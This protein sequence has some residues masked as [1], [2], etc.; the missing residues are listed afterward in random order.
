MTPKEEYMELLPK[1]LLDFQWLEEG[2]RYYLFRTEL[3][4][5][6]HVEKVFRYTP[7]PL[8]KMERMALGQL[9]EYFACHNGNDSLIR[10]LRSVVKSRN[11]VAHGGYLLYCDDAGNVADIVERLSRLRVVYAEVQSLVPLVI[12]EVQ[13]VSTRLGASIHGLPIPPQTPAAMPDHL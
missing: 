6:S 1:V 13:A 10:R 8:K 12:A 11:H 4:I 3:T 2:I 7:S 5:V 9:V